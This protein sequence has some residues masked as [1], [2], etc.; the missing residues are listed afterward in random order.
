MSCYVLGV[1]R[2]LTAAEAWRS[3]PAIDFLCLTLDFG[4]LLKRRLAERGLL[5]H[6]GSPPATPAAGAEEAGAARHSKAAAVG[7]E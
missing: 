7:P 6:V 4:G 5:A 3:G 2:P 1:K